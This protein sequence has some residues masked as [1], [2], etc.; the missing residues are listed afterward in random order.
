MAWGDTTHTLWLSILFFVLLCVWL[1]DELNR[2][3]TA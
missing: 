1:R 2:G 3:E